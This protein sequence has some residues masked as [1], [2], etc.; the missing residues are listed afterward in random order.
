M[1]RAAAE[2]PSEEIASHILP[3]A[4][5]D[6][7][8]PSP[9]DHE[10]SAQVKENDTT[11][12]LSDVQ[13]ELE[14]TRARLRDCETQIV[15]LYERMKLLDDA[16][17]QK[18]SR[19]NELLQQLHVQQHETSAMVS[20]TEA[21]QRELQSVQQRYFR[22][23]SEQKEMLAVVEREKSAARLAVEKSE[24]STLQGYLLQACDEFAYVCPQYHL[25]LRSPEVLQ[26]VTRKRASRLLSCLEDFTGLSSKFRKSQWMRRTHPHPI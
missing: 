20:K 21:L 24:L 12:S 17:A 1:P 23:E 25:P 3:R 16:S 13:V 4:E 26:Q 5:A 8:S 10:I 6:E 11:T 22:V 9:N 19:I 18:D 15:S 7:G 14:N 2:N